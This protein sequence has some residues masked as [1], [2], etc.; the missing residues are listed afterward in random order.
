MEVNKMVLVRYGDDT[1]I[2]K[3]RSKQDN[4]DYHEDSVWSREREAQLR[5]KQL[6]GAEYLT[7]IQV[8]KF[9]N[10]DDE[11]VVWRSVGSGVG[12]KAHKKS[13]TY[14]IKSEMVKRNRGK[15]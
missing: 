14:R 2:K 3:V 9:T 6:L 5:S 1:K 7:F 8:K 4:L 13:E 15:K 11:Y 10:A 12:I